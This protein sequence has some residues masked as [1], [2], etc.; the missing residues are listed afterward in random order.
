MRLNAEQMTRAK[1]V[2]VGDV[3]TLHPYWNASTKTNQLPD[4][5]EVKKVIKGTF[6]QSGLLFRVGDGL[7]LDAAWFVF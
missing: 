6:C 7:E 4:Q 3:V 5:L 1:A 2:K